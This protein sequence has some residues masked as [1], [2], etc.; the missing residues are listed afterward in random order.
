MRLGFIF[1]CITNS[2][3][4]IWRQSTDFFSSSFKK[5]KLIQ[6]FDI[7]MFNGGMTQQWK[8]QSPHKVLPPLYSII[9]GMWQVHWCKLSPAKMQSTIN[10]LA[11]EGK[12]L[13][14]LTWLTISLYNRRRCSWE[15]N[16]LMSAVRQGLVMGSL[17]NVT[18]IPLT[19]S[20]CTF[21]DEQIRCLDLCRLVVYR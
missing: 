8:C 21:S 15:T 18:S 11:E 13:L 1:N 7:C 3:K 6:S 19:D 16:W 4:S 10:R 17:H 20:L 14:Q 9:R 12:L 2:V 5:Q